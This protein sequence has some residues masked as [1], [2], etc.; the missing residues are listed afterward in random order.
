LFQRMKKLLSRASVLGLA[1]FSAGCA[2]LTPLPES[3]TLSE[4]LDAMPGGAAPVLQ[5]VTIYWS[6]HK[7]PFIE[8]KTDEDAAFALGMVHA[9]LRLGQLEILRYVSQGR[10][11]EVAGPFSAI[12]EMEQALRTID[13][14]KSSK[15]V[16]ANM[17]ADSRAWLDNFVRGLNYYQQ[18]MDEL[19]HE[20][21][22][23]GTG[24]DP[25]EAHE[26]LTV[27]RLASVDYNWPIWLT[28]LPMRE[29]EDWPQIFAEALEEGTAS[30]TSFAAND[31][32][33]S[34]RFAQLLGVAA[35]WGSNS[36]AIG[37]GKTESGS[38]IIASD[39]HL[40]VGLPNIWLIAG[41]KSPSMH[42]VGL[43][44]PGMPFVA[45]GRNPDI[46]WGGTSL[47]SAGSDLFD[48]TNI[49]EDQITEREIDVKVRWWPDRKM[50]V[51][52]TPYGPIISDIKMV[53]KREG[54]AFALKW[55]GHL[56]TDELT[57]MLKLNKARNW[58][59]FST[60]L[61][62]FSISAQ[63]FIYADTQGNIG[64]VTATHLPKRSHDMPDDLVL[65]LEK[66]SAWE[67]IVT[68]A[69][70]PSTYNPSQGFVATANNKPSES[71]TPIGYFFSGDDRVLRMRDILGE[72]E[73]FSVTDIRTLQ[74]DTYMQSASVLR[75]ALVHRGRQID[76]LS[77]EALKTLS[78]LEDWNGRYEVE[79]Q[80][81]VALQGVTARLMPQLLD[82]IQL[83]V[84]QT[85]GNHLFNYAN[86]VLAT[87][88]GKLDPLLALALSEAQ[89]TLEE[90]PDWGA[91]HPLKLQHNL[92]MVP[93][94]GKRYEF[95]ILPWPGSTDTI[96]KGDHAMGIS[97]SLTRY[98]AQARHISDMSDMDTN[99]FVL[100]G[101]N[102][103]W[104][105]AENFID[106]A[107]LFQH[108]EM[109]HIPLRMETV[110]KTFKHQTQLRAGR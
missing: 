6:D 67:T 77:P 103:G 8:A 23:M 49:P 93:L 45:V 107:K 20:L 14:G 88:A 97:E 9:H 29:R 2:L 82:E 84:L 55:N 79:A 26:L 21:K 108:G 98:G 71:I 43:M 92:A 51:R 50:T 90:Y 73:Q 72:A 4:R 109:M 53:P 60:A 68:S 17:P 18:H 3:T 83:A 64:Q 56:P 91:M 7:V 40:G 24:R 38:S 70:L 101:G 80:G 15:E 59:E 86:T 46:A 39:P 44:I 76:G 5:D 100:L 36:F 74:V 1:L 52:E 95:D 102:D 33:A 87:D 10:L 37:E 31:N 42:V 94:L 66:A 96:W 58:D 32:R 61:E 25:W 30:A 104:I 99:W 65:P 106:Q 47:R 78:I 16:Y 75:D 63:N 62:T 54:E 48:V 35:K 13:L 81:P 11:A 110:R 12:K 41:V 19:P 89:H 57:S 22:V 105:N 85:G 69:E 34:N 27:G 28:L